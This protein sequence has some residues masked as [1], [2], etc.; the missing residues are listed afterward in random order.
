MDSDTI[1]FQPANSDGDSLQVKP[2]YFVHLGLLNPHYALENEN[3]QQNYFHYGNYFID[4]AVCLLKKIP[5][6]QMQLQYP[7]TRHCF[8]KRIA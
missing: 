6:S 2:K 7:Y 5:G 4:T 1:G 8:Q 3:I